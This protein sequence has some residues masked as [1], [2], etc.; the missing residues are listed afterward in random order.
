MHFRVS[1]LYAGGVLAGIA[2]QFELLSVADFLFPEVH[3]GE[4]NRHSCLGGNGM[5]AGL[6]FLH[7]LARALGTYCKVA[8]FAVPKFMNQAYH[9]RLWVGT[10]NG[11]GPAFAQ[12]PSQR[13][14]EG[15]FLDHH[16][17]LSA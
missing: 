7:G 10:V 4:V 3:V 6:P 8:Y 12:K 1:L 13:P 14:E 2:A 11:E 9:Q 15:L 17:Q 16:A 5:I